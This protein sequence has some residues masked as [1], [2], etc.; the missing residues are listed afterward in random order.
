MGFA[1]IFKSKRGHGNASYISW[2]SLDIVLSE[3]RNLKAF[4][5]SSASSCALGGHSGVGLLKSLKH[6]S[7]VSAAGPEHLGSQKGKKSY[8]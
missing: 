7:Q 4:M 5:K 3:M 1:G 2:H 6:E 8:A